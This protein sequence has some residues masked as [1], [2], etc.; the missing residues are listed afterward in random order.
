MDKEMIATKETM[1]SSLKMED[2]EEDMV[3]QQR[4]LLSSKM[5]MAEEDT[6]EALI[7]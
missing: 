3:H 7:Q 4:L 5:D 6:A 2:M 1:S